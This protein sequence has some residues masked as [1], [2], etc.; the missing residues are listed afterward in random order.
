[1]FDNRR[2]LAQLAAYAL[3]AAF[4]LICLQ[5]ARYSL[6]LG[7]WTV[8]FYLLLAGIP[9]LVGGLAAGRYY[10]P[11]ASGLITEETPPGA[12]SRAASIAE[13]EQTF[14]NWAGTAGVVVR[15]GGL[16][17]AERG[18]MP[19]L[20]RRGQPKLRPP[21]KTLA[22]IHYDDAARAVFE[23]LRHPSPRPVYLLISVPCPTRREFYRLACQKLGLPPP[24][25]SEPLA[26]PP[27]VYDVTRL[28]QDLL[29][30]P[31]F[32]DW[33]SALEMESKA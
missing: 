20:A 23:A 5:L 8:E 10:G 2:A 3:L 1:M 19:A 16:Y 25:F 11:R 13:A 18:P 4:L 29:A 6:V 27:A 24:Q 28:R 12:D 32:P 17:S 14:R 22:L 9:L 15:C 30:Q 7:N 33:R 31:A 21:D 26:T